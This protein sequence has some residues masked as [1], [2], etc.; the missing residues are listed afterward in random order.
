MRRYDHGVCMIDSLSKPTS[1]KKGARIVISESLHPTL[2]PDIPNEC[3]LT[4]PKIMVEG[5]KPHFHVL[6]LGFGPTNFAINIGFL[7]TS[8]CASN[9]LYQL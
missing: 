8:V 2:N 5:L 4:S 9:F 1:G 7:S 6:V 3:E